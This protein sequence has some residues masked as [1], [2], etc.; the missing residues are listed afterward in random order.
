[1]L[2]SC[3]VLEKAEWLHTYIHVPLY[4]YVYA[5]L[6]TY[7]YAYLHIH[8]PHLVLTFSVYVIT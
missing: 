6:Y 1:M 3:R 5:Q 8:A 4:T 2:H 7:I